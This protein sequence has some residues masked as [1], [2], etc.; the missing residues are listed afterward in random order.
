VN[1]ENVINFFNDSNNSIQQGSHFHSQLAAHIG[2][3]SQT[4]TDYVMCRNLEKDELVASLDSSN[5]PPPQDPSSAPFAN[6]V[7]F[8]VAESQIF[9]MPSSVFLPEQKK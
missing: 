2:G 8:E 9:A 7:E 5:P 6:F 3:L 4:V 1:L